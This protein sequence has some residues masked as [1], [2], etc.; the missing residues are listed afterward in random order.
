MKHYL[1]QSLEQ[2]AQA[3]AGILALMILLIL[4]SVLALVVINP[5]RPFGPLLLAFF[6][7]IKQQ[8]DPTHDET[9]HPQAQLLSHQTP[10]A[11]PTWERHHQEPSEPSL[12]SDLCWLLSHLHPP[13]RQQSPSRP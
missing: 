12:E 13:E 9:L 1:A 4:A 3:A 6:T 11:Y 10:P 2:S 5:A 7:P 8:K